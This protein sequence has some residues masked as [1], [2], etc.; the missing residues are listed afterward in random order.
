MDVSFFVVE[1]FGWLLD[2]ARYPS[3]SIFNRYGEL[4]KMFM[5]FH[6]HYGSLFDWKYDPHANTKMAWLAS[7]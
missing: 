3:Q 7:Y 6:P 4:P 1:N 5:F 2:I